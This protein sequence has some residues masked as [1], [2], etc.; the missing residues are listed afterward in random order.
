M[1]KNR[2]EI[3]YG[4]IFLFS[5]LATIF[6]CLALLLV[7][8][9]IFI[10]VEKGYEFANLLQIQIVIVVILMIFLIAMGLF[11]YFLIARPLFQM[12]RELHNHQKLTLRG[13][14]ELCDLGRTYNRMYT[15]ITEERNSL[16]FEA[17]HDTLTGLYNRKVFEEVRD[18]TNMSNYT[19]IVLDI[20]MFKD[21]NDRYGHDVG[22]KILQ[23]MGKVLQSNFR[24]N[25]YPCRIGGDEFAVIVVKTDESFKDL[26][27]SKIDSIKQSMADTSDGL[28][29]VTVSTGVA[30][31]TA[32]DGDV[33]KQA[34]EALYQSKAKGNNEVTF[35]KK[36][37]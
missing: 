32:G 22:D 15:Q 33:Y 23:K 17:N 14:E 36:P 8:R 19:M 34:D 11:N 21:F 9:Y 13:S 26:I 20:D 30:F 7:N 1:M 4:G 3:R 18:D 27:L 10:S 25:D 5:I 35:Y 2:R 16:S 29:E 12:T 37:D 6:F 28:P 31:F 24:S